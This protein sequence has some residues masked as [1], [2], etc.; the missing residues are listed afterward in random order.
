MRRK[1]VRSK[2]MSSDMG[3]YNRP[4]VDDRVMADAD[5]GELEIDLVEL[6]YRMLEKI[7]WIIA[8]ALVGMI[9]MGVFTKFFITPTY[10]ATSKLYVQ[11]AKDKVVDLSS[12]NL[13]DKLTADYVQVFKNWHVHK[14]VIDTLQLPYSYHEIEKMLTITTPANTRIIEIKVTNTN[15]Q[16]AYDIAMA[17]AKAAPAFIEAKM[18]TSRPNIFEEARVP[19]KPAA[20][21]LLK[22][23]V[24]G[25]FLGAMVAMGIILIQFVSDDRIRNA[26]ML[27]KRLGLATLGMMPVQL[28]DNTAKNTAKRNGKGA[29]A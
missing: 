18:E 25:T 14:M 3:L 19:T 15:P 6:M 13:S 21:S 29:K 22:N 12:I 20:P 9:V 24:I 27:Q 28:G 11:E 1:D 7:K 10:E 26:E 8:A 16:E 5:S 4:I 2:V 17:Y 23:A